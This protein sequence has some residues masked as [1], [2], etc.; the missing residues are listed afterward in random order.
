MMREIDQQLENSHADLV[1]APVG[2]GSF[3]QAVVSHFKQSGRSTSVLTVEPDTAACLYKSLKRGKLTSEQTTSTIMT[4]LDCGTPSTIAWPLLQAGVDASLSV[5]D[6]EAHEALLYLKSQGILVGPCGASA[7][8]ALRRLSEADKKALGLT[9]DSVVVLLGTEGAREYTAPRDVSSNDLVVLTQTLVQI[10]SASPSLGSVPGPG[11]VEIARYITAWLEHRDIETHWIEPTKGRPS[12]IGVARGTGGGKSL[13]FNGHIDTVTIMGY[14]DDPLSGK[15]VNGKLYGRGAADMKCGIAAAMVALANA[16]AL[17][18][19]GDVIFAGV[20]DEEAESLGT[21]QI[22][23]AGWRADAAVVNEPTNLEIYHAHKGFVWL[24]V[25]IHG[26]AAHGSRADLGIDAITKAGH[27]LV[28]LDRHAKRLQEG[29]LE[30]K[31]GQPSVHASLI[32]GGEETSSYP[33]LCTLSIEYRTIAGQTSETVKQEIQ[34]LLDKLVEEVPDFKYDLKVTFNR[35]PFEIPLDD[36]FTRLVGDFVG[37]VTGEEVKMSG[38]PFW[39]DC[40]LLAD[41]GIKTLLWGPQGDGLH[42]KEE[43][44]DVESIRKVTEGLTAIA[45]E[46]CR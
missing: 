31:V 42:A 46:F 5:S 7:L 25:N 24:E 11:E 13:M 44:V 23:E 14:E 6:Y 19:P 3:A 21:E 29:T 12:V 1:I 9:K 43:W 17:N 40:A 36:P 45:Q 10:N 8:A 37:K 28:E 18:L 41:A 20:A 27:F 35:S 30:T 4:G 39:T 33:A 38:G 15:I 32:K 22:L 2:V 26:L 34:A 16:K